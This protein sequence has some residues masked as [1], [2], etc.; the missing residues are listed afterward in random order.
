MTRPFNPV[1]AAF[2]ASYTPNSAPDRHTDADSAGAVVSSQLPAPARHCFEIA[3]AEF[4][5]DMAQRYRNAEG[6]T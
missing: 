4:E 6:D 2:V 3:D 5:R 1:I